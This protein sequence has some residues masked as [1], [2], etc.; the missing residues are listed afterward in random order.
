MHDGISNADVVEFYNSQLGY[1]KGYES[2]RNGRLERIKQSLSSF[3]RSGMAVLD[4]GCGTGIT[5]RYM[6]GLG[7]S[8][9][10]VDISPV[11]I[12]YAKSKSNGYGITYLVEEAGNLSLNKTFDV[13]VMADVFEHI[14][15]DDVFRSLWRLLKYHTD[16]TTSIYVN[17]P[18]YSFSRVMN[19]YYPEKQQIVDE[20]WK[21]DDVVSLFA[22]WQFI[23][24]AMRIYGLDVPSQYIEYLFVHEDSLGEMHKTQMQIIYGGNKHDR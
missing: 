21:I 19:K 17:M 5:S 1:M 2:G 11:L 12:E 3:V 22:N 16:K 10:A 7:A 8:V 18:H 4:V 9:T 14:I 6:A 20:A 15:R 13:I 24:A 23:P